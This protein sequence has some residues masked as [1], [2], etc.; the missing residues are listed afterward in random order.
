MDTRQPVHA[1]SDWH[2]LDAQQ[3]L[4]A[5]HSNPAGLAEGEA[6]AR[7]QRYGANRL[8]PPKRRGPLLR[9]LLQ[10]HNVLLYMMIAASAVTALLGQWVDTAVILA[11]VLINALIG[12]IQEGKAEH[13]LD[14]I[15]SMLSLHA[16]VLRD[17]ERRE[18]PAEQLVPGDIV[19][20]VSGDKVPA[21]LRLLKVK[22]FNVEEAALTGESV[23]VEKS[24]ARSAADAVLGDR[25]CMAYSGTLV[26]SGQALGLVVTTGSVTELGRIGSMLQQVQPLTTPLL[27]QIDGFSRWLSV[28]LLVLAIATFTLSTL[29]HGQDPAEMFMM[30]VALTVAAIPEGLSAIMTVILAL[31]VQRMARQ[32]AIVRRLP[33]VE[34]LGSV[35]VICSP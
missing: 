34:T 25:R 33:A 17:G 5:L 8:P 30:V 16:M 7:L 27:R 1:A 24:I 18:I 14:A 28:A 2:S 21:D 29:W 4:D 10:F 26:S 32:N 9:L 6:T 15:R 12:F 11:A 3:A 13:A 20:L 31:G 35:T 23:P 22:N 19:A